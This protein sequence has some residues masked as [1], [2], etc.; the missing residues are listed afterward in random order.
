M[1]KSEWKCPKCNQT[2]YVTKAARYWCSECQA[3][4]DAS[5][6]DP[7]GRDWTMTTVLLEM[8]GERAGVT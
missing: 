6:V 3:E 8:A 4:Q 5:H 1:F 7:M 2:L